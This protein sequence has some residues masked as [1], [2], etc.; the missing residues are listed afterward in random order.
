MLAWAWL[1]VLA[2]RLL[3]GLPDAAATPAA[4]H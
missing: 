3:R 2:A 1:S 4:S